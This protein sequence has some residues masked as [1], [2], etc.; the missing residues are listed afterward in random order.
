MVQAKVFS[1]L[2]PRMKKVLVVPMNWGLGHATRCVPI[3]KRFLQDGHSVYLSGSGASGQFLQQYF[4]RL[5]F[6]ENCPDYGVFY[7]EKMGFFTWIKQW[8]RW[9]RAI[10]LEKKWLNQQQERYNWDIIISDNR[11]GIYHQS[12]QSI[13][14]TH[15]LN[16][17]MPRWAKPL[18]QW[19]FRKR[20]NHFEEIWIP[21]HD[22]VNNLSGELSQ[23]IWKDLHYRWLGPLSR[24]T[25]VEEKEGEV[26]DWVGLVS[27]PEMHRTLFENELFEAMSRSDQKCLLL[28][29]QPHLDF[30]ETVA[31]VRRMSHMSDDALKYVLR[32]AK[33]ITARSG[34]STIM[35]LESIGVKAELIPTPGQS[36]QIYLAAR[37][38]T[39]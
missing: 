3:I 9:E 5:P 18:Y 29:G 32:N 20:M 28:C 10:H 26:Y 16:P 19:L 1:E 21:D 31:H 11:F 24:L 15:Q 12:A 25:H 27:G 22:Q 17:I 8:P 6:I 2:S 38:Q 13:F 23:V 4:P 33:K 39:L 30:D 36:E 37:Y 34:Y 35:D 14:I 7:P